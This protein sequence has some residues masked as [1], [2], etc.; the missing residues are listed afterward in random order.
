MKLKYLLLA[1]SLISPSL[2]A[3]EVEEA[4]I[5]AHKINDNV[6]VLLGG[7]G[8]GSHVGLIIG[9]ESAVIIDSMSD[10]A[11]DELVKSIKRVTSKPV[12]YVVNT[13]DHSDHTGANDYFS[14]RGALIIGHETSV[15]NKDYSQLLY[16]DKFSL[17][18]G[19]PQ[20][21][22]YHVNS[23]SP[24]DA[25]IY[26]TESNVLFM[27]DTF[28]TAWYPALFSGGIAGQNKAMDLAISLADKDTIVVPGHGDITD[29]EAVKFYKQNS[30]DWVNRIMKLHRMGL[31]VENIIKDKQL[32]LI[33]L[34]FNK[35]NKSQERM[36]K[37]FD[38]LVGN[39][40]K[41]ENRLK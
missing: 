13:H 7:S 34:S 41:A 20:I 36:D 2:L 17:Q 23:H 18:G 15:F 39:T 35:G 4:S 40:I 26:L 32:K 25:L 6:Y 3:E 14:A 37:Y 5:L 11:S 33:Q 21:D 22:S 30:I 28:T 31:S 29:I 19:M 8:N 1:C 27:G 10:N 38:L 24:S 16:K 9:E 12:K